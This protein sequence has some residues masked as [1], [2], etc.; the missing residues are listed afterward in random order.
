MRHPELTTGFDAGGSFAFRQY[1]RVLAVIAVLL[2]EQWPTITI[3]HRNGPQVLISGMALP[4]RRAIAQPINPVR[5]S[6]SSQFHGVQRA[7]QVRT[8]PSNPL[9][10]LAAADVVEMA[11]MVGRRC[12]ITASG[13]GR[14]SATPAGG[15]ANPVV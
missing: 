14:W 7:D 9:P 8:S 13:D 10:H 1:R 15:R 3:S 5:P 11:G 12:R 4:Q 2:D 6:R